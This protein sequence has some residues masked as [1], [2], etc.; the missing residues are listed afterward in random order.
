M[1][2]TSI[3]QLFLGSRP[4]EHLKNGNEKIRPYFA[5]FRLWI[6]QNLGKSWWENRTLFHIFSSSGFDE[7]LKKVDAKIR[8]YFTFFSGCE[9]TPIFHVFSV[10]RLDENLKNVDEKIRPYFTLFQALHCVKYEHISSSFFKFLLSPEP[11]KTW[12]GRIFTSTILQYFTKSRA[13]KRVK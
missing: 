3:F 1:R 11:E 2:N 10:S 6:W 13:W 9:N 8:P 5:L 7:I 12:Y 4:D